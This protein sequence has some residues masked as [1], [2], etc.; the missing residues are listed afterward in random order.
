MGYDA[1]TYSD[2]ETVNGGSSSISDFGHEEKQ[3]I[4]S[5]YI[6]CHRLSYPSAKALY[7]TQREDEA[8]H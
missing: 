2:E 5:L 1:F 7:G 3:S 4:S 8:Y 6:P